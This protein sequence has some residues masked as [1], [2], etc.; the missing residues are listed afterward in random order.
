MAG[1]R[2]KRPDKAVYVPPGARGQANKL[3]SVSNCCQEKIEQAGEQ[4]MCFLPPES[5]TTEFVSNVGALM[6][7]EVISSTPPPNRRVLR[8]ENT[9]HNTAPPATR[10]AMSAVKSRAQTQDSNIRELE[11]AVSCATQEKVNFSS[12]SRSS[13]RTRTRRKS[14][15]GAEESMSKEVLDSKSQRGIANSD[16]TAL[17]GNELLR[18]IRTTPERSVISTVVEMLLPRNDGNVVLEV[19]SKT[20][21]FCA[22]GL[23]LLAKTVEEFEGLSIKNETSIS[24]EQCADDQVH[25]EQETSSNLRLHQAHSGGSLSPLAV[26]RKFDGDEENNAGQQVPM[27]DISNSCLTTNYDTPPAEQEAL[28]LNPNFLAWLTKRLQEEGMDS[29]IAVYA[30]GLLEADVA[31]GESPDEKREALVDFIE[32]MVGV[33]DNG[34]LCTP[35]QSAALIAGEIWERW[36]DRELE[37]A[38][39]SPQQG[40]ASCQYDPWLVSQVSIFASLEFLVVLAELARCSVLESC[41]PGLKRIY[42]A[43]AC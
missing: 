10:R 8:P 41:Y 4:V 42:I 23:L 32:A 24:E 15:K 18:E 36:Q 2:A 1:L 22:E 12:C 40:D 34:G 29:V 14:Q 27:E 19:D 3:P 21:S 28:A 35:T 11:E 16:E 7:C 9:C 37:G 26:T 43:L 17:S 30:L 38:G 31:A 20:E 39:S 25:V 6:P 13:R 33:S 5:S